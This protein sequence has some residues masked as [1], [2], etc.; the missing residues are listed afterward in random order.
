M[1]HDRSSR[2]EDLIALRGPV[3]VLVSEMAAFPWDSEKV[4]AVLTRSAV[5][6]ILSRFLNG[7]LTALECREWAE[8]LIGRDDLAFEAGQDGLI[9]SLLFTLSTPEITRPLTSDLAI[10]CLDRL[11][12]GAPGDHP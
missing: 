7:E 2:L 9:K 4:L 5:S 10:W 6:S 12:I 1:T 8:A 11:A 3:R